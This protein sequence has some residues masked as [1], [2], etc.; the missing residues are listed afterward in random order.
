MKTTTRSHARAGLVVSSLLVAALTGCRTQVIEQTRTVYVPAPAEPA[1]QPAPEV[2][3]VP[4]PEQPPVV[5][6][7]T[8]N[9]FYEPLAVYGR[10]EVV[11]SYGRCWVPARVSPGWRP[12]S[13][14]H[15]QR[16]DAGWYWVSDEPW[17]WA[18][19]HY[20]RWDFNG[21]LG[22]VWVPRTEWAPAWVSWREG[23]GYVGWA[24]LPP[25]MTVSV[26]VDVYEPALVPRAYVFVENRRM[27]EPVRPATVIVNN[28]TVIN[29]TVNITKVKIVNKTVI[30][31]GPRPEQIERESG[32]KVESVSVNQFR[33][34]DEETVA[35]RE[36]NIP[37][38]DRKVGQPERVETKNES[39]VI[40]TPPK[41]REPTPE[42]AVLP[43]QDVRPT[44]RP[45]VASEPVPK[46]VT[47]NPAR[48]EKKRESVAE[49]KNPPAPTVF[50]PK[51]RIDMRPAAE[52]EV[53]SPVRIESVPPVAPNRQIAPHAQEPADKR[54]RSPKE[55]ERAAKQVQMKKEDGSKK[56]DKNQKSPPPDASVQPSQ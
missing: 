32:H 51:S 55:Q 37:T 21:T 19:Y 26:T 56:K 49:K 22:W 36:R 31:E 45:V 47:S 38:H 33:H 23:G 15:W 28:T 17:G 16:T 25:A 42:K 9:D 11:G 29:K 35:A 8:V 50:E 34:H 3:Y 46:P 7:Q 44:Q 4:P 41:E 5:V 52:R 40:S 43:R 10:W 13:N 30:N 18:T 1:P 27:V 39:Q 14:G 6:I 48:E 53:K 2:V 24:P 20:G 12:Y 54:L